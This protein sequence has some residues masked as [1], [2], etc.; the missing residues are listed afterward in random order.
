MSFV[1]YIREIIY[2]GIDGI[3][4]TFAIVSGF[5]GASFATDTTGTFSIFLVLLFGFANLFADGV[6][7]GLGNF[8]SLRS[9]KKL[10][11]VREREERELLRNSREETVAIT[12]EVLEERGFSSEDARSLVSLFKHNEAYWVDFLMRYKLDMQSQTHERPGIRGTATFFAFILFGAIP[13]IPFILLS[14][15][16]QAFSYSV[17]GFTIA[18]MTLGFIRGYLT[19]ENIA[20]AIVEVT[21]VGAIA[22]SIAFFIGSLF[23]GFA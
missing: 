9:A 16:E 14:S 5:S 20:L 3:I 12:L 11:T 10:Y 15:P 2:G 23:G 17:L 8:L 18:L 6:S 22:G 4:T 7:M 13:I 1:V 19:K 21:F